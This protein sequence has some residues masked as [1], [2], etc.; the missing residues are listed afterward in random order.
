[1]IRELHQHRRARIAG[2]RLLSISLTGLLAVVI[3]AITYPTARK[4]YHMGRI[5]S[6]DPTTRARALEAILPY[7]KSDEWIRD[8]LVDA[9]TDLANAEDQ[10]GPIQARA[11]AGWLFRHVPEFVR[12]A[13]SRLTDAKDGDAF[14]RLARLL[15]VGG[16]WDT[17]DRSIDQ[18]VRWLGYRYRRTSG[19]DRAE[20]VAA[21]AELGRPAAALLGETLQGALLDL[22]QAVRR[23]AIRSTAIVCGHDARDRLSACLDDSEAANRREAIF[24]T[25]AVSVAGFPATRAIARRLGDSDA[26]VRAAAAWALA[27]RS[28]DNTL[29]GATR[30]RLAEMLADDSAKEVRAMAALAVGDNR[31]LMDRFEHDPEVVVRARCVSSLRPPLR[32][33]DWDRLVAVV[34][35]GGR[36]WQVMA[37]IAAAGR[38]AGP[39]AP[40]RLDETLLSRLEQSLASGEDDLAAACLRS[41]GQLGDPTVLDLLR[42]IASRLPDRPRVAVAAARAAGQVDPAAGATLLLDTLE[43]RSDPVRDFASVELALLPDAVRPDAELRRATRSPSESVRAGAVLAITLIHRCSGSGD[44]RLMQYLGERT[45]P[46]GEFYESR[47][48]LRGYYLCG[49]LLLGDTSVRKRVLSLMS[50]GVLSPSAACLT[51]LALGDPV[52]LDGPLL[53]D[54]TMP[55]GFDIRGF[56]C[57]RRFAEIIARLVPEAP[58]VDW[59]S[60]PDMQAW[61][62]DRLRDWWLVHR[63]DTP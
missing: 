9:L 18:R 26:C 58:R 30:K 10:I 41:L 8:R 48:P 17:A 47:L 54:T 15:I 45:D 19:E 62:I 51:F 52:G 35:S 38:C 59:R 13:E 27:S 42:Q 63:L 55:D 32:D 14:S 50:A 61:Q 2:R 28:G 34:A 56:L 43:S 24:M 53:G 23:A 22:S 29:D 39:D 37:A 36:Y 16:R 33:A 4:H 12:F 40:P 11:A 44:E 3:A 46:D 57:D 60:D 31:L 20:A 6:P 7:A 25:A 1:M 21:M 49:R 5:D